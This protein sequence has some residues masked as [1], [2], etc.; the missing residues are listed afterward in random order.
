[1]NYLVYQHEICPDTGREHLQGYVEFHEKIT[2]KKAKIWFD[3]TTHIDIRKGNQEQAIE[4]ASRESKRMPDTRVVEYG[5]K[6][7]GQGSR[8]DLL[9]VANT[10]ESLRDI[11][12]VATAYPNMYI[13]YHKGMEKLCEI[14]NSNKVIRNNI[15]VYILYG[16]PGTGK[17]SHVYYNHP[18]NNIY[19]ITESNVSSSGTTVWFDKYNN[20][21]VLLIDDF[22]GWI[23]YKT[24][25]TLLDRYPLA[26]Q[27]KGGM[28]TAAWNTVYI[29][30][31]ESHLCWYN[32]K[33]DALQRR[34]T[35]VIKFDLED[36]S[37]SSDSEN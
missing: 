36:N 23:A 11:N 4:Y 8:S 22:D 29:T 31:N 6:S 25:I 34:I 32:R 13:K 7:L 5:N 14:Y 26:L 27:V 35:S 20:E 1:M 24:L 12:K 16:K 17:T 9:Q 2:A 15:S 28:A 21:S 33:I 3:K 30:T 18:I 19:K 10:I 37:S